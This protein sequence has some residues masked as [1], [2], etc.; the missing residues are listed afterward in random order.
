MEPWVLIVD[1][2]IWVELQLFM[3][4]T[5]AVILNASRMNAWKIWQ[6]CTLFLINYDG[7]KKEN[8]IF[9]MAL[10]LNFVHVIISVYSSINVH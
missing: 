9:F 1:L 3:N 4:R 8:C 7:E 5:C 2:S 10:E 6:T